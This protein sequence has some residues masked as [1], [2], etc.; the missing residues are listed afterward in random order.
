MLKQIAAVAPELTQFVED[1]HLP[2]SQPQQRHV[3]QI[4]DGLITIDGDKNLSN[5]YRHFVHEPCPKSAADTFREAPWRAA[6]IRV[7]LRQH[8]VTT[9]LELA[10]AHGAPKVIFLSI[11]DSFTEKDR[12]ST[13]LESVDWHF[14]RERSTLQQPVYS[15]GTV[16]VML[17][18][19]VGSVSLTVDIQLYLRRATVRLSTTRGEGVRSCA[20]AA[21]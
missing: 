8:L 17:R 9:A 11:D 15:K 16:Y 3:R 7:P 18:L 21:R 12:H 19:I 1:L 20:F 10:E 4:A 2:L 13:R 6:D 14:D 5:L